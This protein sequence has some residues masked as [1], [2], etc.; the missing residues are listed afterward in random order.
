[1]PM[2]NTKPIVSS[3][4]KMTIY[5]KESTGTL[6]GSYQTEYHV[7]SSVKQSGFGPIFKDRQHFNSMHFA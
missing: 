1:M 6:S 7:K 3:F 5:E 2:I 4:D